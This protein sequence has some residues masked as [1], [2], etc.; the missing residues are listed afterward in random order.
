MAQLLLRNMA[1]HSCAARNKSFTSLRR[2]GV[3]SRHL[4]FFDSVTSSSLGDLYVRK[5]RGEIVLNFT[6]KSILTY[7]AH[8]Q[9]LVLSLRERAA[10][11]PTNEFIWVC[12]DWPRMKEK[13]KIYASKTLF[14]DLFAKKTASTSARMGPNKQSK[15]NYP[16][17]AFESM[18]FFWSN[19]Y[20][21]LFLI[22]LVQNC[23][24]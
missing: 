9:R 24:K 8:L 6:L 4:Q 23:K 20:T 22:Y 13:S 1:F 5:D 11:S 15:S 10:A 19:Q 21:L 3:A 14:S 7:K 18:Q 2:T 17:P 12:E 16:I